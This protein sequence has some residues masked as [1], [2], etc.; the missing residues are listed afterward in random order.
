MWAAA[1]PADELRDSHMAHE[2]DQR[3]WWKGIQWRNKN[4]KYAEVALTAL[5]KSANV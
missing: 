5:V 4:L 3:C 2:G 1:V